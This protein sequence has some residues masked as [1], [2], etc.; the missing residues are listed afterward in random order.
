M[1]WRVAG[2]LSAALA[3]LLAT[4]AWAWA[5][6]SSRRAG[7][8]T[9]TVAIRGF[10]FAPLKL[11]ADIGD[12]IAWTNED[13]VLHTITADTARWDSGDL[14]TGKRYRVVASS[15]GTLAYHCEFHPSMKGTLI[16]R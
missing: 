14:A 6:A 11:T 13:V 3:L 7:A 9:R 4:A 15:R 12:T 10:A 16:I 2:R 8:R 5:S 1:S